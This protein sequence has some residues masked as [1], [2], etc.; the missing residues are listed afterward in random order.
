MT[1]T[2]EAGEDFNGPDLPDPDIKMIDS[3]TL[4]VKIYHNRDETQPWLYEYRKVTIP[5]SP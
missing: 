1:H 2:L 4:N 3:K 5:S